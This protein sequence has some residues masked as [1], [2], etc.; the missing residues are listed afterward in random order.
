[1]AA[2]RGGNA[3]FVKPLTTA[4]MELGNQCDHSMLKE[5]TVTRKHLR[6]P[7]RI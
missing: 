3:E 1:M 4:S 2:A 5:I 6:T 7:A